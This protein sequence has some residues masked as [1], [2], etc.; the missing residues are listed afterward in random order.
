[1]VDFSAF[2]VF[3]PAFLTVASG[4]AE[5]PR[6]V[7]FFDPLAFLAVLLELRLEAD[8]ALVR[9]VAVDRFT[10]RFFAI[11]LSLVGRQPNRDLSPTACVG[12]VTDIIRPYIGPYQLRRADP[13][14]TARTS[15]AFNG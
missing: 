4:P 1:V 13:R 14:R 7:R 15:G 6:V 10:V 2:H 12:S 9:F 3:L 8:R 11:S 5:R